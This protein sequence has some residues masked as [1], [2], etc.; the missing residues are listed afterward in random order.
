MSQAFLA[1]RRTRPLGAFLPLKKPNTT[2]VEISRLRRPFHDDEIEHLKAHLAETYSWFIE[3]GCTIEANGS[4]LTPVTFD[5]FAFPKAYSPRRADFSV[6]VPDFGPVNVR[7]EAGLIR[8]RDPEQNN[9]GV[10]VYCNRRLVVKEW[11]SRDVGYF[12]SREAGVP[13]P[14]ASLS[15]VIVW[16]EGAARAMP[17]NSSKSGVDTDHYIFHQIRPTIIQLNSYFSS[18]SRRLKNDW[19]GEVFKYTEGHFD[20]VKPSAPGEIPR[21][22]LP[23]LPR[24]HKTRAEHLKDRNQDGSAES[25]L[26]TRT[27]G[28]YGSHRCSAA[29]KVRYQKSNC[30]N[31]LG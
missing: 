7:M 12:V 15:R 24:V 26:D 6:S 13:H 9:Y 21:M 11:Q 1:I 18:L 25:A 23:P 10:Y 30:P 5:G 19:D 17:W 16:L 29:P 4:S 28:G 2:R 20:D 14:D 22:V 31:P 3:Q 8:D 27:R